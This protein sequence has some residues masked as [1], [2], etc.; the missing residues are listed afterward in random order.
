MLHS[1][2]SRV[3]F[4]SAASDLDRKLGSGIEGSKIWQIE[5]Q[6]TRQIARE[7]KCQKMWQAKCHKTCQTHVPARI[8][9]D[10]PGR[11]SE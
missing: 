10:M 11:M 4:M 3:N 9:E 5:F 8:I 6:K 2:E 7:K 1:I